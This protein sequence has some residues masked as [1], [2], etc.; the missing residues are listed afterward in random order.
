MAATFSRTLRSLRDDGSGASIAWMA[1]A[2]VLLIAWGAWFVFGRVRVLELSDRARIETSGAAHPIQPAVTGKVAV[3]RL[4]LDRH[5]SPGDVLVELDA[6]TE[7]LLLGEARE[8]LAGDARQKEFLRGELSAHEAALAADGSESSAALAAS[9]AHQREALARAA[10]ARE[11]E[12]RLRGLQERGHLGELELLRSTAEA[13]SRTAAAEASGDDATRVQWELRRRNNERRAAVERIHRDIAQLEGESL[14]LTASIER[15]RHELD[16]RTVR[17][18]VAGT[19]AEAATLP[20]GSV[21]QAGDRLGAIVPTG[22]LRVVAEFP[23]SAVGRLA[24]GQPAELRLTGFPWTE[25]GVV[26]AQV[27]NVGSE[28][29]EG[30]VR[31]ELAI[32]PSPALARIPMQHGLQGAVEVEVDR[33]APAILVLRSAGQYLTP[34]RAPS[35]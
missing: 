15:L 30:R 21:V 29:R 5:V 1:L 11:E 19:I 33:V 26:R 35:P 32:V 31:V 28:P 23:V 3:S 2:G 10:L 18:A 17:A 13:A 27:S 4:T 20:T 25:Y 14:A 34:T 16:R 22:P 6:T 7:R 9:R 24:P 8:R 12:K